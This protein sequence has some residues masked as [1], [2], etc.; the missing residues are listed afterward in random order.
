MIRKVLHTYQAQG[1]DEITIHENE[2]I[3]I[4][5]EGETEK[6]MFHSFLLFHKCMKNSFRSLRM[7]ARKE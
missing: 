4:Y 6:Q 7:V 3:E 2:L 1:L 5:S